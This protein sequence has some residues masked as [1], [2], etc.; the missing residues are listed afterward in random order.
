[1]KKVYIDWLNPSLK[2]F[3]KNCQL[4][5]AKLLNNSFKIKQPQTIVFTKEL[6]T[7]KG[8]EYLMREL[9]LNTKSSIKMVINSYGIDRF[10]QPGDNLNWLKI[11]N[12]TMQVFE[13][14]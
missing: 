13:C 14:Q 7:S 11:W 4:D 2:H 8:Y 10:A 3:V 1:M 6:I 12:M 9:I 5:S